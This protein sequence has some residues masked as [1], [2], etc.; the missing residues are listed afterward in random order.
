MLAQGG[1]PLEPP[2][3]QSSR[4]SVAGASAVLAQHRALALNARRRAC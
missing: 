2:L 1:D 3:A 4:D